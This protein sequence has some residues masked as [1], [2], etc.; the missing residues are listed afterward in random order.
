MLKHIVVWKFRESAEG[1]TREENLKTAKRLLEM[2]PSRIREIRRF[3]VGIDVSQGEQS[4]DLV[5][6]SEFSDGQALHAYQVHPDHVRL[7]EFLRKVHQ[8]RI[9]VDYVV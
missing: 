8:G 6:S 3:E 4:Y 1:A 2:L 7:V 5:L 9:V